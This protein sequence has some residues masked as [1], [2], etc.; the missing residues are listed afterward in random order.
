MKDKILVIFF[1]FL[2]AE[3]F[4][5]TSDNMEKYYGYINSAEIQVLSGRYATAVEKYKLAFKFKKKPFY[6]DVFNLS[7]CYGLLKKNR[8]CYKTVSILIKKGYPIDSIKNHPVF[9]YQ[10]KKYFIKLAKL[11]TNEYN[12]NYRKKIDSLYDRDQVYRVGSVNPADSIMKIDS[13]NVLF[14]NKLIVTYGFPSESL[15]GIHGNFNYN[16]L[17]IIINHNFVGVKYRQ[18]YDYSDILLQA[19]KK[20]DIENK[21]ANTL[22]AGSIGKDKYYSF[23][24]SLIAYAIYDEGEENKIKKGTLSNFGFLKI[25]SSFTK[26]INLARKEL[27]L[28]EIDIYRKKIKFQINNKIFKI[29]TSATDRKIFSVSEN[30]YTSKV[31][32][33]INLE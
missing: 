28:D 18:Y 2:F 16:S 13:T 27:W 32:K 22:I 12:I 14:L 33:L 29:S 31:A 17:A 11:N 10:I 21:I 26:K 15:V 30:E 7:V 1:I 20:G 19:V 6:R 24:T 23:F 4:S 9:S 8:K 5:K 3:S 25:D